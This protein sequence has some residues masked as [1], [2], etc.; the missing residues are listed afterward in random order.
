AIVAWACGDELR[1][2]FDAEK[3]HYPAT[4]VVVGGVVYLVRPDPDDTGTPIGEKPAR[5]RGGNAME[6]VEVALG[7][8]I[9]LDGAEPAGDQGAGDRGA[10]EEP[11]PAVD[12]PLP[13]PSKVRPDPVDDAPPAPPRPAARRPGPV[14]AIAPDRRPP[15][16]MLRQSMT[17]VPPWDPCPLT[18]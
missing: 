3:R 11:A 6:L 7:D 15:L 9:D 4:S 16:P 17:I 10:D 13:N 12:E 1:F 2:S 14:E 5:P 8:A 18:L